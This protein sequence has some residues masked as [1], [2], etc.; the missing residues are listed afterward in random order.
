MFD[1]AI[2]SFLFVSLI[3]ITIFLIFQVRKNQGD[4][5][6][7]KLTEQDDIKHAAKYAVNSSVNLDPFIALEQIIEAQHKT[8]TVLRNY[9]NNYKLAE[10]E[11]GYEPDQLQKLHEKIR[12]QKSKLMK[13]IRDHSAFKLPEIHE[14]L[15]ELAELKPRRRKKIDLENENDHENNENENENPDNENDENDHENENEKDDHKKSK[16]H[17]RKNI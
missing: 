2:A 12:D 10:R 14:S 13:I 7:C 3:C 11:L 9:R 1:N 6:A 15:Q 16:S 4:V 8:E 17:K 5:S